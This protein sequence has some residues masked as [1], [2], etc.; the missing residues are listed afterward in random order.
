MR[1]CVTLKIDLYQVDSVSLIHP[2]SH[3]SNC[4]NMCISYSIG[5]SEQHHKYGTNV[6]I[7]GN[8]ILQNSRPV[9]GRWTKGEDHKLKD[10][11]TKYG[12]NNWGL[13]SA[14]LPCRTEVQCQ[15]RWRKVLTNNFC[16]FKMYVLY[17]ADC[18]R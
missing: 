13:I 12:T 3:V 1:V 8:E 10:L 14:N 11:C 4:V 18:V 6:Q 5:G 15:Q 7:V 16:M 17:F 9:K 2:Y